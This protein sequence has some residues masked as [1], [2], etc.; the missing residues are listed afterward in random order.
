MGRIIT[1]IPIKS[2]VR[3]KAY[4]ALIPVLVAFLQYLGFLPW[5]IEEF[6]KFDG[7]LIVLSMLFIVNLRCEKCGVSLLSPITDLE[8]KEARVVAKRQEELKRKGHR[9]FP[10]RKKWVH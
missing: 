8:H 6:L 10:F 1:D 3:V 9:V 7:L 2:Y 5:E 4:L